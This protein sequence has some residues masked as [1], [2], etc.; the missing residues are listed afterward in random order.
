MRAD[1]YLVQRQ[2]RVVHGGWLRVKGIQPGA[3]QLAADEGVVQRLFIDQTTTRG[4]D[5]HRAVFHPGDGCGV[6][7]P[8]S[9]RMQRCMQAQNV[10]VRHQFGQRQITGTQGLFGGRIDTLGVEINHPRIETPQA[11]RQHAADVAKTHQ[12]D[13]LAADLEAGF[14]HLGGW[15]ASGAHDAV[16][17]RDP[18]VDRQHEC[19]R[20]FCHWRRIRSRCDRQCQTILAHSGQVDAVDPD[21]PLLD[22]AC[23]TRMI[24]QRLRDGSKTG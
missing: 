23:V 11:P 9:L 12:P 22:H 3:A 19:N 17:V 18:P 20:Q 14:T 13:R 7:H 8:R 10:A 16:Y 1:H 15:P 2:Q 4:V 5:Q 24:Q 21:A 6:D